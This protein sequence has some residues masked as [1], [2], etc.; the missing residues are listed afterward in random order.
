MK[1]FITALALV[2]ALASGIFMVALAFRADFRDPPPIM[3]ETGQ[4]EWRNQNSL[5]DHLPTPHS[6]RAAA[7]LGEVP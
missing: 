2:I 3:A 4:W 5:P 1:T 7:G 6:R